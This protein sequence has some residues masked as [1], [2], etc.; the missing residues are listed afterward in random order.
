M[1]IRDS[2]S[3]LTYCMMECLRAR[4]YNGKTTLNC[5]YR[6]MHKNE[7]L[8]KNSKPGIICLTRDVMW[9]FLPSC[10]GMLFRYDCHNFLFLRNAFFP[11]PSGGLWGVC[12]L[13][14][15]PP[16][17]PLLAII[18]FVCTC[19]VRHRCCCS[20]LLKRSQTLLDTHILHDGLPT[21]WCKVTGAET[22]SI[23]LQVCLFR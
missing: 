4:L 21:S 13:N 17:P 2:Y 16:L 10:E 12:Y 3:I 14:P 11:G 6:I 23:P 5:E 19:L 7:K 15:L 20:M 1:C 9:C 22:Q 18:S 8:A